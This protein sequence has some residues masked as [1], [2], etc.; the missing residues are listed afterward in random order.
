MSPRQGVRSEEAG[1]AKQVL[2]VAGLAPVPWGGV[3][4]AVWAA[5]IFQALKLWTAGKLSP[6]PLFL[7]R[8]THS[9]VHQISLRPEQELRATGHEWASSGVL[10]NLAWPRENP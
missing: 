2:A 3:G 6:T 8:E 4:A 10:I 7:S 5:D 1:K 9:V